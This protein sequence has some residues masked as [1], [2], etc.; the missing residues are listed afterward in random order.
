MVFCYL[1]NRQVMCHSTTVGSNRIGV[2]SRELQPDLIIFCEHRCHV[3]AR[4]DPYS[5]L[6]IARYDTMFAH[7]R[8]EQPILADTTK[9]ARVGVKLKRFAPCGK[10]IVRLFAEIPIT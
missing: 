6:P 10:R 8:T 5:F 3:S 2:R 9:D 4:R 1:F 7:Y